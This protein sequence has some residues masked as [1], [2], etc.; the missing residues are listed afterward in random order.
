[1]DNRKFP[2]PLAVVTREESIR[3]N[4]IAELNFWAQQDEPAIAWSKAACLIEVL[5][6]QFR[7]N[8]SGTVYEEG[9]DE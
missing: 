2:N 7:G 5:T 6:N 1:M 8:G 3:M 4:L 9:E